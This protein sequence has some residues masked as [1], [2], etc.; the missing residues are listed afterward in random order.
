MTDTFESL[1]RRS[2]ELA[3]RLCEE[4]RRL[5]PNPIKV[6]L[7]YSRGPNSNDCGGLEPYTNPIF[8]RKKLGEQ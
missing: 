4:T 5:T 3:E 1:L 6:S 7:E 2:S 8:S